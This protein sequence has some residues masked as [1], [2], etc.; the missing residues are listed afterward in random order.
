MMSHCISR[1]GIA[2][3]SI[4]LLSCSIGCNS[5]KARAEVGQGEQLFNSGNYVQAQAHFQDAIKLDPDLSIAH[6]Y[7]AGAYY[8]EFIHSPSS[9]DARGTAQKSISEFETFL[10]GANLPTGQQAFAKRAEAWIYL[11]LGD[12]AKANGLYKEAY[13]LAANSTDQNVKNQFNFSDEQDDPEGYNGVNWGSA[14]ATFVA[15]HQISY[16]PASSS[17]IVQDRDDAKMMAKVLEVPSKQRSVMGIDLSNVDWSLIPNKFQNLSVDGV[18]YIFYDGK[19]A[20][21]FRE[22]KAANYSSFRDDIE[23]KYVF[24]GERTESWALQQLEEKPDTTELNIR[25]YKRG[26][27]NTRVYLIKS[28][29]HESIGMNVTSAFL[30]YIPSHYFFAIAHDIA[31]KADEQ[32]S[33]LKALQSV[34][35]TAYPDGYTVDELCETPSKMNGKVFCYHY[36]WKPWLKNLLQQT[37]GDSVS[38]IQAD[39]QTQFPGNCVI[40]WNGEPRVVFGGMRPHSGGTEKVYFFVSPRTKQLDIVWHSDDGIKYF[41][42]DTAFLRSAEGKLTVD[43]CETSPADRATPEVQ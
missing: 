30:L 2:V 38:K 21:A 26:P 29:D 34:R 42:P 13:Q 35:Y 15:Q 16:T 27:S 5:R 12:P 28:I 36:G 25:L 32:A 23:S 17:S 22:L 1:V 10:K 9:T 8:Q 3:F 43:N 14:V 18:E 11:R 39:S 19:L 20:M 6:L 4:C 41:G 40:T 31:A 7:L 33:G 24:I 37:V